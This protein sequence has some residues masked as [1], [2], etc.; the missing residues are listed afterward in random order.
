LLKAYGCF[1][2]APPTHFPPSHSLHFSF[3]ALALAVSAGT[4]L[5]FSV[6]NCCSALWE[7]V[8]RVWGWNAP[9]YCTGTHTHTHTA[10]RSLPYWLNIFYI[11]N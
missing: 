10:S 3:F 6:R 11:K 7:A 5:L 2:D 8:G 9:F 1:L 4:R